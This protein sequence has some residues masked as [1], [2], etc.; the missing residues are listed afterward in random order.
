MDLI[1]SF[2]AIPEAAA[3]KQAR[4]INGASTAQPKLLTD[5]QASTTVQVLLLKQPNEPP[6]TLN[7][8]DAPTLKAV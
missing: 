8:D 7:Q 3:Q 1:Q 6:Q 4:Q 2:I 5:S